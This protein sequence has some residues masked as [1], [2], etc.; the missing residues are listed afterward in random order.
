[1]LAVLLPVLLL[2]TVHLIVAGSFSMIFTWGSV[3]RFYVGPIGVGLLAGVGAA[4]FVPRRDR[5]VSV[6]QACRTFVWTAMPLVAGA[7]LV[8]AVRL[9]MDWVSRGWV[10]P[11]TRFNDLATRAY[12]IVDR[13]YPWVMGASCLVW[14]AIW[15]PTRR[16]LRLPMRAWMVAPIVVASA[17]MAWLW[18]AGWIATVIWF[19]D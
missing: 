1:M 15:L 5:A 12:W 3:L 8:V 14:L 4:L 2:R 11:D 10:A 9:W 17:M 6:C 16:R 18:W 19:M 7:G 13:V